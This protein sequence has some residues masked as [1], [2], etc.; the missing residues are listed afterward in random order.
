[1]PLVATQPL[2][3]ARE[4]HECAVRTL[5]TLARLRFV[6]RGSLLA[7]AGPLGLPADAIEGWIAAGLVH[8]GRVRLDP[9]VS[10]DTPYLALAPAGARAIASASG[11]QVEPVSRSRMKRTPQKR[12]H[13]IYV[14]ETALT[15]IAAA[16]DGLVD[17]IGV[18]TDDRKLTLR[19]VLDEPGSTPEVVTLRPDALVVVRDGDHRSALLVEVD[20][21][22]ISPKSMQRRYAAYLEWQR[23]GGAGRDFGTKALRV[24]TLAPTES[25][26]KALHDAALASRSGRPCGFFLFAL[27]DDVTPV[28]P[29]RLI[30]PIALQLGSDGQRVPIF[31]RRD[32]AEPEGEQPP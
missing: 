12:A 29:E 5:R 20:R 31:P 27:Q 6:T 16:D 24:L 8:E 21:G 14:G 30:Q 11:V 1:M 28:L 9:L 10:E 3:V 13:D 2:L 4:H 22:T 19:V 17:L 18:E 15:A 25:R 32:G 23:A 26:L 7:W